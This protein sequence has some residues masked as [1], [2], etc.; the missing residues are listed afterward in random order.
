MLVIT[1][2]QPITVIFSVAEDLLPE[3]QGRLNQG[4]TLTVDALDRDQKKNLASGTLLTTDNQIDSTTGTVRLRAIFPNKDNSL[5][6]SQFVNASL[7]VDTLRGV[8]IVPTPAIQ[9]N[10]QGA[11]VYLIKP[12]QT[13]TLR[14]VTVGVTDGNNTAVQGLEPGEVVASN[15]FDKLQEGVKVAPLNNQNEAHASGERSP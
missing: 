9:R 3:I 15:G 2:L 7:L 14:S 6:P 8:T 11:F 1:Q 4:R 10:A 12:D 5:F 13:A